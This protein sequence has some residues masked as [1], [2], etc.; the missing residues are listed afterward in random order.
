MPRNFSELRKKMSPESLERAKEMYREHLRAMPLHELRKAQGLTQ[1]QLAQMLDL[2][3]ASVSKIERQ[4]DL[5]VSTLRRFVAACG[6]ELQITA[7]F[8]TGAI[9]IDQFSPEQVNSDA[10]GDPN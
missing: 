10:A 4:T 6:G 5:Y 7:V 3:Q 9:A 1:A 2:K 8:P